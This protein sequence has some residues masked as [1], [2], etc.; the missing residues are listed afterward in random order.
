[1]RTC[2]CRA[3]ADA[4]ARARAPPRAI[5][6]PSAGEIHDGADAAALRARRARRTD[7]PRARDDADVPAGR[8][9]EPNK[10]R[11]DSMIRAYDDATAASDPGRTRPR[12]DEST[13]PAHRADRALPI[14][15]PAHGAAPARVRG[16]AG[17]ARRRRASSTR[18]SRGPAGAC[19]GRRC[20]LL[21]AAATV[22][23]GWS[24]RSGTRRAARSS[25]G[26]AAASRARRGST[27]RRRW[28]SS[29]RKAGRDPRAS[30]WSRTRTRSSG[31][32]A[33]SSAPTRETSGW[34]RSCVRE[35]GRDFRLPRGESGLCMEGFRSR[36]DCDAGAMRRRARRSSAGAT[37]CGP[38]L[39]AP[40]WTRRAARASSCTSWGSPGSAS[41]DC[42]RSCGRRRRRRTSSSCTGAP[43][44]RTRSGGSAR[45]G[46]W[47]PTSAG[48]EP[49]DAP[50]QRFEK[51]ERLR[52]LGPRAP[53]DRHRGRADRARLPAAERRASSGGRA[54]SSSRWRSARRSARWRRTGWW[55]WPSRTCSGWTTPRG[56]SCPLLV[57][58]ADERGCWCW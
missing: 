41:R 20:G 58:G 26:G 52:V 27:S 5:A 54:G 40:H 29:R 11:V 8:A 55:C 25:C 3:R 7:R 15:A 16:G 44:R 23:R 33:S 6:T 34:A 2:P 9:R 50:A 36:R 38:A 24:G 17:A 45:S 4:G 32:R 56:R 1:M 46:T 49:E 14:A 22:S 35:L 39:R 21:L 28:P 12:L 13:Q 43:T 31:P 47:S 10:L 42:S 30:R 57:A 18:R 37:C 19:S 51:V 53:R 48:V